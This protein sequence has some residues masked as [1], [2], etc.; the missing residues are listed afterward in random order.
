MP[1]KERTVRISD[2][3]VIGSPCGVENLTD[4]VG[5]KREKN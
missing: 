2:V 4:W 5:L 3:D 1:S